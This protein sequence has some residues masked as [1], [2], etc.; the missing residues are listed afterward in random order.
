MRL[1]FIFGGSDKPIETPLQ[2]F[3]NSMIHR[4]LGKDNKYHDN[5]SNYSLTG[6]MGGKYV[7][8][9][10]YFNDGA[11]FYVSSTDEDFIKLIF[12]SFSQNDE[13]MM[14]HMKLLD[15]SFDDFEVQRDYDIVRT[16]SPILLKDKGRTITFEDDDF[17]DILTRKS[18]QKLIHNGFTEKEAE[19]L[20][21]TPFHFENAKHTY[22]KVGKAVNKASSVMIVVRGDKKVR[23]AM[24]NMG[25]GKSTGCGFGSITIIRKD[26]KK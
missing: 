13:L 24:Y 9:K 8:G 16:I 1:K 26:Y 7:G 18:R 17:I 6:L 4:M 5:F 2:D 10:F 14:G 11:H 12:E 3:V 20:V 25:F 22:V 23:Y 21:L 19:T 15:V